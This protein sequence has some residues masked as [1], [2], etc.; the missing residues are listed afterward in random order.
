MF[1]LN[2]TDSTPL[3]QQ[4]FLQIR[5]KVLSGKFPAHFKLPS[6]RDLSGELEIS[7]N[8]VD[9]A[10]QELCAEGYIY[11]KSRSGYFVSDLELD[12]AT[13]TTTP[14]PKQDLHPK[15]AERYRFDFHPARLDPEVFPAALWKKCFTDCFRSE[16][17]AFSEYSDP[18]GEWGLRCNVQFYLERSRGVRCSPDQIIINSGSQQNLEIVAQLIR[19]TH[20]SVAVENPG[21]HL[22]RDVFRN[23]GFRINPIDIGSSSLNPDAL[24]SSES[25]VVYITPS[26][27]MPLGYVMPVADRLKLISWADTGGRLIIEDDYDS[28]LRYVGRPISSLQGLNPQGNIIYQGTFS[29]VFSP[30]LRLCYMVLPTWLADAYRQKF[31]NYLCP[32]PLLTQRAMIA[33]MEQG[34]W[35]QHLRR[36]RIFYKKKHDLML[37]TIEQRL[38]NKAKIIGQGAGLHLV[39]ELND[40]I[41]DE[42]EFVERAKQHGCRLLPFSAFYADGRKE[43]NKLLLGF[44]GIPLGEIPAGVDLLSGLLE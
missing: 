2:N 29:K 23:L 5:E 34:H 18:Q 16:P 33:F 35:E 22:P 28:E 25:S 41:Q 39:L 24:K 37:H 40:R 27:Q 38:L 7:R 11:S 4:L 10:F 19:E 13:S 21:Y 42:A 8:T 26:H 44:G 3:Y 9:G 31:M 43:Q 6:I 1:I 30:A 15:L 32:V 17:G 14:Y 36:V 20:N 12:L